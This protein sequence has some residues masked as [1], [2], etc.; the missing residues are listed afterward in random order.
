[1]YLIIIFAW[2]VVGF[3]VYQGLIWRT[4]F[5][6]SK[7]ENL[8]LW[9][10]Y[11]IPI[12]LSISLIVVGLLGIFVFKTPA[13]SN[14]MLTVPPVALLLITLGSLLSKRKR[15]SEEEGSK[16]KALGETLGACKQW[17]Q[18]FEFIDSSQ[19][20]IKVYIHRSQPVG[21]LVI[22]NITAEQ[23]KVIEASRYYL[24]SNVRLRVIARKQA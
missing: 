1:M 14:A 3:F 18:S 5:P 24:P 2:Y 8:T 23:A 6:M 15:Y 10:G 22:R 11:V 12:P 21:N 9:F 13:M 7:K 20:D 16:Q 19:V 17:S 4:G